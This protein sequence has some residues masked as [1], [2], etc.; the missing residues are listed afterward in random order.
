MSFSIGNL[1]LADDRQEMRDDVHY[2]ARAYGPDARQLTFL[3]VNLSPHGLM[4]RCDT[5][6]ETGDRLRIVLPVAGTLVAEVRWSLGGRL[7][8]QFDPAIDLA[9]YYELVAVL[10]KGK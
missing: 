5:P 9:S 1:A 3:V 2:R 4:A 10:L 7:G 8:C 6:F